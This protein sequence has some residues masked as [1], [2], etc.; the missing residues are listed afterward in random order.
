MTDDGPLVAISS[1]V[2]GCTAVMM[3]G[4]RALRESW[5]GSLNGKVI[6][7]RCDF[8][9]NVLYDPGSEGRDIKNHVLRT[10]CP[11]CHEMIETEAI[12]GENFKKLSRQELDR[13]LRK[14]SLLTGELP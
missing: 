14:A 10:S 1:P 4:I 12:E 9:G 11:R 2:L 3:P 7:P 13:I 8:E 6:C 5:K